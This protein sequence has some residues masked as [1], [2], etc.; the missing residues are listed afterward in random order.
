[1]KKNNFFK[2][3]R[4]FL[5]IWAG[6]LLFVFAWLQAGEMIKAFVLNAQKAYKEV[7]DWRL[8]IICMGV[9]FLVLLL[10]RILSNRAKK[11]KGKSGEKSS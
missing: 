4:D 3:F 2:N 11:K 1:M 6:M 5:A 8:V 10:E 9:S 7:T